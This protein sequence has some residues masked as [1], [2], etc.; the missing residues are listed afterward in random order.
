MEETDTEY[1]D[2]VDFPV[3]PYSCSE[4]HASAN[5]KLGIKV[6]KS[7]K[8]WSI[9]IDFFKAALL[10]SPINFQNLNSAIE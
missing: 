3:L 1:V 5:L 7:C 4:I 6:P 2:D 10:N 8:Q 9:A